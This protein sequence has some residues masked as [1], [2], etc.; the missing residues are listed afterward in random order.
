LARW[1][2]EFYQLL[3]TNTL[4]E[5]CAIA[6]M[7]SGATM[8]IMSKLPQASS[9]ESPVPPPVRLTPSAVRPG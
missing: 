9:L 7:Q 5:A 6:T 1:V 3:W 4:S 8:A 2:K